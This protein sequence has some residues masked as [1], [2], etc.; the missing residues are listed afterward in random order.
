MLTELPDFSLGVGLTVRP[1]VTT[2][3]GVPAP[4]TP[5]EGDFQP[6]LDLTQRV[7]ANLLSSLTVNTDF[8]ETEVDTRRT[9]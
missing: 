1:A 8:A 2:G 9:I 5:V 3:G 4:G 7:G 6:S